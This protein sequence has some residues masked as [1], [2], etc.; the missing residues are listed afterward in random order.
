MLKLFA[1]AA[2]V[3]VSSVSACV[4]ASLLSLSC[5]CACEPSRR[6]GGAAPALLPVRSDVGEQLSP[7]RGGEPRSPPAEALRSDGRHAC[8]GR[9]A[10]RPSQGSARARRK[11]RIE[12]AR[13]NSA[14]TPSIS[15][16][17]AVPPAWGPLGLRRPRPPA[18]R[19]EQPAFCLHKQNLPYQKLVGLL[20]SSKRFVL[21]TR[22]RPLGARLA[23][24]DD[25]SAR[26]WTQGARPANLTLS[27]PRSRLLRRPAVLIRPS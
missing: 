9:S 19:P 21:S 27:G 14:S 25:A 12:Q 11:T 15:T 10:S 16:Q 17:L 26:A 22:S 24:A 1:F 13:C 8:D 4:C 18:T 5:V 23:A 20:T 2:T 6:W 7:Q 3:C